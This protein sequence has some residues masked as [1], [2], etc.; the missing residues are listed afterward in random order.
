MLN[1]DMAGVIANMRGTP[2]PKSERPPARNLL[3]IKPESEQD[4]QAWKDYIDSLSQT[5]EWR[6]EL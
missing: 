5:N 2:K 4:K 3:F 1:C 6:D